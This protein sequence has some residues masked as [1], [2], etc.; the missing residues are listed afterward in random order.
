MPFTRAWH[1][2]KHAPDTSEIGNLVAGLA[3]MPFGQRP[4]R[5]VAGAM[6]FG[7]RKINATCDE[8]QQQVLRAFGGAKP[9]V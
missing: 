1:Q 7:A 2:T 4:F 8:A 6:D 9:R 5:T 3:N